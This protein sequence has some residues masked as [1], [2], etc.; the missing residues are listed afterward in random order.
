MCAGKVIAHSRHKI[1]NFTN[2]GKGEDELAMEQHTPDPAARSH[3]SDS[4]DARASASPSRP[5]APSPAARLQLRQGRGSGRSSSRRVLCKK[6]SFSA[7][8]GLL[9]DKAR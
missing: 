1:R 7:K 3:G 8:E 5:V 4:L 2:S 6:L 9:L